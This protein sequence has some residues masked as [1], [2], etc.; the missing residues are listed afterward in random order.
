MFGITDFS[1]NILSG[2]PFVT[3]LFFIFLALLAV[4]LY[5]RTNPPLSTGKRLLLVSLRMIAVIVLFLALLEPVVSYN[6]EFERK[7]RVTVLADRSGSMSINEN[8]ATREQR[9]DSILNS[10][11]FSSFSDNFEI[12]LAEFESGLIN[13]NDSTDKNMTPLGEVLKAQSQ[14]ELGHD[15]EYW[16]LLSDGISNSGVSPGT[17]AERLNVP[18]F[19]LGIGSEEEQRDLSIKS[20]EHNDLIFAGKPAEVTV[21]LEWAGMKNDQAKISIISGEKKLADETTMLSSG[22]MQKEFKL[23]FIPERPGR[24]TIKMPASGIDNEIST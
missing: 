14:D 21:G 4:Y 6:R 20:I 22:Q 2:Y 15:A 10:A 13:D 12:K 3:I 17:V 19:T 8:G 7:P 18:I 24:Q 5:R 23:E 11:G 16:L 9:V 1:F